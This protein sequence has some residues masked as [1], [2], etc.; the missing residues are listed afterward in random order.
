MRIRHRVVAVATLALVCVGMV[1]Y[2]RPI[3]TLNAI[4][5]AWRPTLRTSH[6]TPVWRTVACATNWPPSDRLRS[7]TLVDYDHLSRGILRAERRSMFD[8]SAT[9]DHAL[10]SVRQSLPTHAEA[11][12]PCD[13]ADTD[14][15]IAQAW[16]AGQHQIRLY[17]TPGL[18]VRPTNVRPYLSVQLLSF[19]APGCGPR[20]VG[21]QV[22]A[23]ELARVVEDRVTGQIGLR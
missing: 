22:T 9:W 3:A 21:R 17:A 6:C 8:D 18:P 10:D 15:P 23:A 1:W 12:L 19:G 5:I 4:G 11:V 7:A 2:V 16:R 20:Y 14:F 13:A